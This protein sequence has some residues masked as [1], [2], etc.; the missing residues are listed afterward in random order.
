MVLRRWAWRLPWR[1][2]ASRGLHRHQVERH[3]QYRIAVEGCYP[4]AYVVI[5][6]GSNDIGAHSKLDL[7]HLTSATLQRVQEILPSSVVVW[8]CILPRVTL[9]DS[10]TRTNRV[11][12]GP[13][14]PSKH[15]KSI[16]RTACF[17]TINLFSIHLLLF[18]RDEIHLSIKGCTFSWKVSTMVVL[19]SFNYVCI[20]IGA[21]RPGISNLAL[22]FCASI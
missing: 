8:S 14:G 21:S 13:G 12:I 17:W 1:G 3:I 15:A 16:C 7:F 11:L 6:V 9:Q 10:P 2:W 22:H 19:G 5:H 4:Y 20:V 18:R